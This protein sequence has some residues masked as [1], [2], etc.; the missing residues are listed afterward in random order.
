MK[1]NVQLSG[2]RLVVTNNSG[3]SRR[4][5]RV[6]AALTKD[7]APKG[8]S[9][10]PRKLLAG[11]AAATL[12]SGPPAIAAD[13]I[14][15]Q[16]SKNAQELQQI[17]AQRGKGLELKD[18]P[19]A[20][21]E[22]VKAATNVPLEKVSQITK[23]V[24]EAPSSVPIPLPPI[25]APP[26]PKVQSSL[27]SAPTPA[28]KPAAP[29][30]APAAAP[31]PAPAAASGPSQSTLL[32]IGAVVIA[33]AAAVLSAQKQG[34]LPD[35]GSAAQNAAQ[36]VASGA[37]KAEKKAEQT[38]EDAASE[39]KKNAD[40]AREWIAAWRSTSGSSSGA[41]QSADDPA[42]EAKTNASEAREWIAAWR[43]KN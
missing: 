26:A 34:E 29:R 19:P 16:G 7:T 25:K 31:A 36:G 9:A 33:G 4:S 6:T 22:A 41:E 30:A 3:S 40:G 39:A 14:F 11:F 17:V 15:Q 13:S 35:V 18:L 12:L 27:N 24:V 37:A 8:L 1:C 43:R 20:A 28:A 2:P 42:A 21:K 10:L 23:A 38:V 5:I 32:G